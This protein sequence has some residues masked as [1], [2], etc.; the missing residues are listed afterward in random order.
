MASIYQVMS[1]YVSDEPYHRVGGALWFV[2]KWLFAYFPELSDKEPTFYMT[3]GLHVAH[4]LHTMPSDDLMS[5]F[6]GLVDG[7]LLHLF[8]RPDSVHNSAWN[9][10]LASSQPY[11]H[12]FES[13]V[14]FAN[15]TFRVLILGGF[16][17]F[18]SLFSASPSSIWT[19]LL[20][21]WARQFCFQ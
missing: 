21:L 19:Y 1:K 6:L 17:A 9:E 3:L 8:F 12:D 5:F 11:L 7:A 18:S 4:S 13:P 20:C 16:F 15:A 2:Q 14:A 10:I